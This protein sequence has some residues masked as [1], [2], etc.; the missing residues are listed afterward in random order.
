MHKHQIY[1]EN[2]LNPIY[3]YIENHLQ[4]PSTSTTTKPQFYKSQQQPTKYKI[5]HSF[6]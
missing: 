6:I 2:H 5:I 4:R 1:L 3:I